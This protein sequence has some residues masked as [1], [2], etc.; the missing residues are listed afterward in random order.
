MSADSDIVPYSVEWK[1][2]FD[3]GSRAE[4]PE[5]FSPEADLTPKHKEAL[6]GFDTRV[7][8]GDGG[9]HLANDDMMRWADAMCRLRYLRARGWDL[10]KAF[11]LFAATVEWRAEYQPWVGSN[12]M[13]RT[14]LQREAGS[15]K[16]YLAGRDRSGR[17][18]VVMRPARDNTGD[19][20]AEWK[21]RY[22]VWITEK[23]VEM[24]RAEVGVEKMVWIVEMSGMK[25]A[26]THS[27]SITKECINVMQSHYVE[28]LGKA[29]FV[30]APW[31]FNALWRVIS[32]FLDPVTKAKVS[33]IKSN[34]AGLEELHQTID[35]SQLE[36]DLG[37]SL[38][39]NFN[40]DHWIATGEFHHE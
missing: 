2:H 6:E 8:N 29:F 39:Q 7:A 18:I 40:L 4:H 3:G 12:R 28:R 34:R 11:A 24:M 30:N 17:P 9:E 27:M 21:V 38:T 36:E 14:L 22:L 31:L 20:D 16:M 23:A 1:K 5:D 13:E 25:V 32:P 26:M 19:E 37:G 15:Q 10:D 35:P 33:F